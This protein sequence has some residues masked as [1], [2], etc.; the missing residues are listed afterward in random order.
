MFDQCIDDYGDSSPCE[1]SNLF[2]RKA[3]K[4]YHCC[5]C[6]DIIEPGRKYEYSSGKSDGG[7]WAY[8][9]CIVCAAIRKDFFASFYFGEMWESLNELYGEHGY[10]KEENPDW[11]LEP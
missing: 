4:E 5:E 10:S 7:F 1:L 9:T 8:K 11:W 2:I 3:R 6:G